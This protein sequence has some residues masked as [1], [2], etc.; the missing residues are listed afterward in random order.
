MTAELATPQTFE[1]VLGQIRE[2][3][4]KYIKDKDYTSA[5]LAFKKLLELDNKDLSA[6]F[7]YAQLID[8]GSHKKRA[9][10]RDMMLSI[11]DE[12][13]EIF[14]HPTVDNLDLI[15]NAAV[16]CSHVGPF[17][18]AIELFRKLAPA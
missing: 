10:A 12:T 18:R 13:P 5:Q 11:L 6:R 15:R 3:A 17:P 2:L 7:V 9:E 8:D 16:R 1:S 4:F 14:D